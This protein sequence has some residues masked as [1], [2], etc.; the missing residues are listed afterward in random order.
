M[1]LF[2]LSGLFILITCTGAG[3]FI[4]IKAPHNFTNRLWMYFNFV[5]SLFGLAVYKTGTTLDPRL[6]FY[7]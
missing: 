7:G 3:I 1:T 2:A 6:L 4:L 5:I